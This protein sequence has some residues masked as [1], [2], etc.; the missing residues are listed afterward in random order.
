MESETEIDDS[1]GAGG[2]DPNRR[3]VENQIVLS[4]Y[5]DY[6]LTDWWNVNFKCLW[7]QSE[8]YGKDNADFLGSEYLNSKYVGENVSY[9]VHN[10]FRLGEFATLSAGIDYDDQEGDSFY[11][12]GTYI[13]DLARVG[14]HNIGYYI[15]SKLNIG[16]KFHSIAGFRIDDH[17]EFS[18]HFTYKISGKYI[19]DCGT[20]LR[21]SWATGF[22]APSLADLYDPQWGNTQLEP[23]ESESYEIAVGQDFFEGAVNV[24]STYFYTDLDNLIESRPPTWTPLNI[25][26]AKIYGIENLASL[27]LMDK[28]KMNYTY[29]YLKT[30]DETTQR[31]LLRRP[32]NK[33]TLSL[34][35]TPI[36]NLNCNLSY[37]YV[38]DRKDVGYVTVKRYHKVDLSTRYVI[39]E[40]FEVH[41]RIENLLNQGYQEINGYGTPGISFYAG[42]KTTF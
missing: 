2:D 36:E 3:S 4:G 15:Q 32:R 19:F 31:R 11:Q 14:N 7:M 40:N 1:G 5:A 16:D 13:S 6:D 10:I 18:D 9:E 34:T 17:S 25:N 37:L 23:E 42:G 33:H 35:L 21:S 8:R 39:N 20:S 22:R 29:T 12:S 28:I 24:E 26:Q 38:G 30:K 41:G 27:D